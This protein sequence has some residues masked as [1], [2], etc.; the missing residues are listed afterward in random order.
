MDSFSTLQMPSLFTSFQPS[1]EP[2]DV[3]IRSSSAS[4]YPELALPTSAMGQTYFVAPAQ[5][6]TARDY[7]MPQ[8]ITLGQ[9]NSLLALSP[10]A[11]PPSNPYSTVMSS[12]I[13]NYCQPQLPAPN[14]S[15][16]ALSGP[17]L[18][19]SSYQSLALGPSNGGCRGPS[20]FG[21]IQVPNRAVRVTNA[22]RSRA[23]GGAI[24]RVHSASERERGRA[25]LVNTAFARLRS[26]IPTEPPE[27]RLSKIEVLRL[28]RTYINHLAADL[29]SDG[30][31]ACAEYWAALQSAQQ[32][33]LSETTSCSCPSLERSTGRTNELC[34]FCLQKQ[35]TRTKMSSSRKLY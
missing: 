30:E 22:A 8:A 21:D 14:S 16:A 34:I 6:Q 18:S 32:Q 24:G 20:A 29:H 4:T 3:S 17:F 25:E 27:R 12:T 31:L 11:T 15:F 1:T 2:F 5:Q 10:L 26:L 7:Q 13:A 9:A 19:P 35:K 23:A 33:P 28:A